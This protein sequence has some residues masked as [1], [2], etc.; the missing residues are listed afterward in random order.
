[1]R[2]RGDEEDLAFWD[3]A[4]EPAKQTDNDL[5]HAIHLIRS[6]GAAEATIAEAEAYAGLAK[7]ALKTLTQSA[8][9]DALVD[10]ADFCVARAH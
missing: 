9:T 1:A 7:A 4:L 2:R 8:Y 5:A 10:L 6:T 3:R